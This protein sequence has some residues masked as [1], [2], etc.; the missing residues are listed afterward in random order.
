VQI[1]F[2]IPE[3]TTQVNAVGALNLLNIIKSSKKKIK[4]YQASTSEMFGAQNKMPLNENSKMD[5]ASPYGVAKLYAYNLV[6][7]YRDSYNIF[8]ANGIL[9]NHESPLRGENFVTRKITIGISKI[10]HG[11][12]KILEIGNFDSK[13]DWGHAKDYA[14]AIWKILQYKK[15]L[16]LVIATNKSYSIKDFI[17]ECFKFLKIKIRFIGKGINEKVVDENGKTWIK[18]NKKFI[19]PK[20]INVLL[21]NASLAKKKLKWKNK[22]SFKD[23]TREMIKEDLRKASLKL[24]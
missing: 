7:N 2:E 16:D 12:K 23:L 24:Y 8:A 21:G 6:R 18:I 1:S 15:P 3:Y 5:P 4:F 20:D 9:F 17:K 14:E 11:R 19:R 10:F 22:T 13:R